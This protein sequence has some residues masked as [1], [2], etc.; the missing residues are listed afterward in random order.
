M[1]TI[2]DVKMV[3]TYQLKSKIPVIETRSVKYFFEGTEPDENQII[4]KL[5]SGEAVN[6]KVTCIDNSFSIKGIHPVRFT[7]KQIA[8]IE[9]MINEKGIEFWKEE[10]LDLVSTIE[11]I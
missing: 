9:H 2:I 10:C 6:V 11:K 3:K 7:R 1:E 8:F 5:I 4:K